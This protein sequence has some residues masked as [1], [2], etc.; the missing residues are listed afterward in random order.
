MKDRKGTSEPDTD[1][2]DGRYLGLLGVRIRDLRARR[3]MTRKILARDSGV[4]ERY[5]AQLEVGRGNISILRLRDVAQAMGLPLEELISVGPEQPPELTLLIQHLKRLSPDRL[6]EARVAL[7]S[8][9]ELQGKRGRI[10]LIGLRG[11]GKTT[12]GGLLAQRLG[13]PFF[14]LAQEIEREAGMTLSE[15]FSLNG[16]AAYRRYE[17]R[18]LQA[19]AEA[20]ERFVLAPGGSIV[21]EPATFGVLLSSCF[22]I[23]LK[24]SPQEHM[25]RVVAQGDQR[26]MIDNREAMKDLE[27][28]LA[29]REAMYI[30]ADA[31]VD[32]SGR[33]IDESLAAL[34]GV[35]PAAQA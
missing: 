4:S 18:A 17:R 5:L 27:R 6:A 34:L 22:T 16:Q 2:D 24:A 28:I 11:A 10:A 32:T 15:I 8:R 12:L 14:E 29:G 21:S 31:T 30:K 26:P 35:V 9:S 13:V 20:H 23:W 25:A 1:V 33:S 19:V 7:L 3:G